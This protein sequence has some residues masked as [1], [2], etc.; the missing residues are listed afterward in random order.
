VAKHLIE[1]PVE[2]KTEYPTG[3]GMLIVPN[4]KPISIRALIRN[5]LREDY[6]PTTT[7]SG[8]SNNFWKF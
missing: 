1:D 3:D 8:M 4:W 2:A 7:T 6:I 5:N